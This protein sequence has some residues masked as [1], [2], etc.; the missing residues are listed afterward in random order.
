MKGY[1]MKVGIIAANNLRFSPYVFYYTKI[2]DDLNI[3]YEVI[4]PNRNPDI[5]DSNIDN[6]QYIEWDQKKH[7]ILNYFKLSKKAKIIAKKRYDYIIVLTTVNAVFAFKWL[8]KYYKHKYIVDI[9]D[10]TYEYNKLF[11]FFEKKVVANASMNVIS[12]KKFVSFLP[13]AK[14]YVCHNINTPINISPHILKKK[15]EKIIIGYVGAVT[16]EEQCKKMMDLVVKDD[17][18]EFHIYGTGVAEKVLKKYQMQLGCTRIKMYGAY[19]QTEKGDI[20]QKVDI[21]FNAYGNGRPLVDCAISNKLYDALYY[22][23]PILTSPNTYMDELGGYISYAIDLTKEEYLD[24]LWEW[25]Q[26]LSV[27]EFDKY[28]KTLYQKVVEENMNTQSKLKLEFQNLC[29]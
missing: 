4:A 24:E 20:I 5:Q 3:E 16:Y 23:K 27:K 28:V 18:F 15:K 1:K 19:R 14:Y 22:H 9:R 11:Y 6:V 29:S 8:E 17:R 2:L 10:Y 25:Y 21:L 26:T 12:S 7:S 13:E